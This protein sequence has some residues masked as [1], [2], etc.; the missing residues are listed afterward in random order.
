MIQIHIASLVI[1]FGLG[2]MFGVLVAVIDEIPMKKK[3]D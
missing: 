1:G 3:D 2:M